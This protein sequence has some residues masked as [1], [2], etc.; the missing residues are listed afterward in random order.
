MVQKTERL[1]TDKVVLYNTILLL[2]IPGTALNDDTAI[3]SF[4][5]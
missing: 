5:N 3:T 4:Q 2:V 1:P